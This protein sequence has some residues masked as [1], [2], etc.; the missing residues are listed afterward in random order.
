[1]QLT[2]VGSCDSGGHGA[3]ERERWAEAPGQSH[4]RWGRQERCAKVEGA[5]TIEAVATQC[6]W[7][8]TGCRVRRWWAPIHR[9]LGLQ[10]GRYA[11]DS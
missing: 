6:G 4:S 11:G 7:C 5:T 9:V 3:R 10:V 1:M 2:Y 8:L